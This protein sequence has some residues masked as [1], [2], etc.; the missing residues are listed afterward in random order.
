VTF[1]QWRG[2]LAPGGISE[3]KQV[4]YGEEF[5]NYLRE[6]TVAVESVLGGA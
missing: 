6:Y 2:F 1:A 4:L 3:E 5:T